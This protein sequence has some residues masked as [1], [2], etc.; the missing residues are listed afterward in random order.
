MPWFSANAW[1]TATNSSTG[2]ITPSWSRLV[3]HALINSTT[4]ATN[5]TLCES[6]SYT[7][8]PIVSMGD[9]SST[10]KSKRR[11]QKTNDDDVTLT[12]LV[13]QLTVSIGLAVICGMIAQYIVRSSMGGLQDDDSK[14][15]PPAG[16]VVKRLKHILQKRADQAAAAI[17]AAHESEDADQDNSDGNIKNKRKTKIVAHRVKLPD[18]NA[19]ELQM[20]NN[21]L[22]PDDIESTFA[23]IGGLD[24]TKEE[25]YALAILPLIEP[26]LFAGSALVQPCK[27]ILLYGPPGTG[28]TLLA[29][30][31]AKEAAAVFL[32]LPLSVIL[33]KWMGESNK[34]VAAAFSLANKLAP[35][36]IFI[37]EI[38]TFLKANSHETAHYDTIKSEFLTWW[39]GIST[40]SASQVLVLGATNRPQNIDSAI[41]RRMPRAFLVPLPNKNG[42]LAILKLFLK[43]E[44]VTN[45][46]RAS[47]PNLAAQTQGYSGSDLKELCK[48]AAMVRIQ[49]RTHAFSQARTRGEAASLHAARKTPLRPISLEDMKLA[50]TKVRKTGEAAHEFGQVEA[51]KSIAQR[52]PQPQLSMQ[53][54][55]ALLRQFSDLSIREDPIRRAEST[56]RNG[57]T[58]GEDGSSNDGNDI[59]NMTPVDE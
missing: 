16:H 29:K 52:T 20:A 59:P 13:V 27:G 4:S 41:L 46:V 1:G 21:V 51:Q 45:E 3:A 17:A 31:L 48:T 11:K 56:K 39:D 12:E 8:S 38:D 49:E 26:Q 42:R 5:R 19:H 55:A 53:D 7:T 35:A 25:L 15:Q 43:D 30:A 2:S 9:S 58:D 6:P 50:R 28:K 44:N 24:K 18:L 47:L 37:D 34:L 22:D 14:N 32:P 33:N 54:L 57:S 40:K 23:H 10:S 36:I